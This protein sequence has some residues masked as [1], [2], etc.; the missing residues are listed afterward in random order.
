VN[1][2][3][4]PQADKAAV[5]KDV[6]MEWHDRTNRAFCKWQKPG[7]ERGKVSYENRK[8]TWNNGMQK[9]ITR[10]SAEKEVHKHR[11]CVTEA[12]EGYSFKKEDR[13]IRIFCVGIA[14]TTLPWRTPEIQQFSSSVKCPTSVRKRRPC[15]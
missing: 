8:S 9:A 5:S 7:R 15:L 3:A 2:E 14:I 11:D 6:S 1:E 13:K 10:G 4:D 12:R